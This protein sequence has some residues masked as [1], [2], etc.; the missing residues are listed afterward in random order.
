V[1]IE[2]PEQAFDRLAPKLQAS[3]DYALKT[4]TIADVKRLVEE[5]KMHFWP[6]G[7]SILITELITFPQMKILNIFIG[8]GDADELATALPSLRRWA[9]QLGCSHVAFLGREGWKNRLRK[10]GWTDHH[11][12]YF[13][14]PVDPT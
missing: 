14:I 9:K 6:I 1:E 13:S 10:L 5:G 11:C 8:G 4:H 12:S 7:D 3:L 2:P